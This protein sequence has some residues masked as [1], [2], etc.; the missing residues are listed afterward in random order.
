MLA[1][2]GFFMP[3]VL[4]K[5][6][7]LFPLSRLLAYLGSTLLKQFPLLMM[8]VSLFLPPPPC[9]GAWTPQDIS[10]VSLDQEVPG[11]TC[12]LSARDGVVPFPHP[13]RTSWMVVHSFLGLTFLIPVPNQ[14][15]V[16]NSGTEIPAHWQREQYYSW[17]GWLIFRI[18][19]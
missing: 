12:Q 6:M 4:I 2:C 3:S 17:A 7:P 14:V 19:C 13:S 9:L 16:F 1:S 11:V 15:D 18:L 10:P 8:T 5:E